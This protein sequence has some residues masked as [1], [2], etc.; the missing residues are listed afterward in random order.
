MEIPAKE[1]NRYKEWDVVELTQN[2]MEL[3]LTYFMQGDM[4]ILIHCISGWDRTP[5]FIALLRISL[6]ADGLIHKS[7]N[8]HEMAYLTLAYDWYLFGHN[9]PSRVKHGEEIMHFCFNFLK[10]FTD[11]HF[12]ATLMWN[13]S[14]VKAAASES[15]NEGLVLLP[16]CPEDRVQKI[17]Q[18]RQIVLELYDEHVSRIPA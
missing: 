14:R 3:I 17:Q 1:W 8:A 10:Y 7:L 2:Y 6:W 18:L 16:F 15:E 9:L 13:S 4:S 11:D 5:L 12:S